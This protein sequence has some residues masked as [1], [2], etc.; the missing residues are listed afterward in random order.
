MG[1]DPDTDLAVL[2]IDAP[3]VRNI[4]FA[5]SAQVR[6]GQIAVAIGNPFGYD[7][8]VTAGIVSALGDFSV[9]NRTAHR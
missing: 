4:R 9:E 8:T 1:D 5:N 6:V 2:R 7:N 3:G